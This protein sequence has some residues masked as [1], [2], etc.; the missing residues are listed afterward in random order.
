MTTD[1]PAYLHG[2]EDRYAEDPRGAALE[3]FQ[4]ANYGLFLHYG[5]Y[6]LLGEHE[7]VQE[8][9]QI[10]PS[11][12]AILQ[13]YF[14]AENFDAEAIVELAQDAGMK[15]INLTTKH[16]EGFCLFDSDQTTF[17]SVEA[18]AGR[19][20]VGELANACQDAGMGLFLYYSHGIDWRHPHAPNNEEWGHPARPEYDEKPGIYADAGHDLERYLEYVEAQIVELLEHYGPIAGIWLDLHSVPSRHPERLDLPDLYSTI[21]EK[22]PQTLISYKYGITGTEDFLAPEHETEDEYDK[23][24]EVCTTMIPGS[25]YADELELGSPVS[26]GYH[27]AAE[28]KHKNETEVWEALREANGNGHN[29]LLNTGPMPEGSIEPEDAAVFRAI[30]ER[31]REDGYPTG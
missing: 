31:I 26:W 11:E 5:L 13:D 1:V 10:P 8:K 20:L 16:H 19:D 7:W 9:K 28:G 23:P 29:L 3:W 21:R 22:Q 15:Y 30:G 24:T 18:P 4:D 25:E 12:Y 17:T 27:A 2:Y 14:T 6:S